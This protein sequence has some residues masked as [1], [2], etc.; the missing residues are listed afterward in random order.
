MDFGQRIKAELDYWDAHG[1]MSPTLI[2]LFNVF[3]VDLGMECMAMVAFC[4][5]YHDY[6][7]RIKARLEKDAKEQ[8][9]IYGDLYPELTVLHN[10]LLQRFCAD[11]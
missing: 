8:F 11:V 2:D 6:P 10:A 5:Q 1:E 9:E 4:L 7:H 3:C